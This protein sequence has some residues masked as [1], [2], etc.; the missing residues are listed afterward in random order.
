MES[1]LSRIVPNV[2]AVMEIRENI[3]NLLIPEAE[4]QTDSI[5]FKSNYQSY[6]FVEWFNN[7][8]FAMGEHP[9][10]LEPF[11]GY[12]APPLDG[13]WITAPYLHNGSVPDL[14]CLLNSKER[15]RYWSPRF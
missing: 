3:L 5:L 13:I 6:Q 12:I 10:R 4:I 11:N 1:F 9:A 14:E 2:T 8:W 7:S 15:P